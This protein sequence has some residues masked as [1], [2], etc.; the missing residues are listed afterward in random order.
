M[1]A[2]AILDGLPPLQRGLLIL[3]AWVA[4]AAAASWLTS[5][6]WSRVLLPLTRRTR[7]NLDEAVVTATRTTS[8]VLAFLA[9]LELGLRSV[10]HEVPDLAANPL[11]NAFGGI[12][13]VV[14]V[15]AV[16]ALAYA[17][18]KALVGWHSG[19]QAARPGAG[20]GEQFSS[21]LRALAK[22]V[23]AFVALTMILGHFNVQITGL[24]AT[25]GVASLAV[26]FAAQETLANM[27]A[28]LVLMIDRPFKPGDRVQL[29]S[30]Q[31][32]DV[33]AIGLRSTE[34]L[35]FDNTVIVIPNSEM[36]K[37]QII[38]L[39][40]PNS[41]VKIRCNLGVAYGTDLRKTKAIL[42]R[43]MTGHAEVLREPAP[44]VY[45]TE[46]GESALNLLFICWVADYREKFR[47][48][49]ELNMAIKDQFE[50]EAI[51]IPFP[52]RALHVRFEERPPT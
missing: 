22:L 21:L 11:W 17:A 47:I 45:F 26:A 51:E 15:L 37:S 8:K 41:S 46:F 43:I 52:Q 20:V 42:M 5:M 9:V 12:V 1:P 23:L 4:G 30:G 36:A 25:A 13:F 44:A 19:R 18:G 6:I 35:S 27:I 24:L 38:N 31:M 16:T 3:A 14:T 29:A 40:A 34:V 7:T 28:G 50:A 2:I 49:D 48:Q 33:M 32:G 39:N 10:S